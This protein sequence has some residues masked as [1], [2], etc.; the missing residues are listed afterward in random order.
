MIFSDQVILRVSDDHAVVE[1]NTQ[2]FGAIQARS[3]VIIDPRADD[4]SDLAVSIND[5]KRVA[6]PFNR[7]ASFAPFNNPATSLIPTPGP[8]GIDIFP[9]FTLIG[10]SNQ[11]PYF[12]V[13]NLYS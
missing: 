5:A 6:A 9:S 11:L 4:G 8:L 12:S 1:V 10:E 13:P 7:Y 2:M 3:L